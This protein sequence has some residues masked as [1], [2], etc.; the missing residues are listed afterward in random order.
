MSQ[1]VKNQSKFLKALKKDADN[2]DKSLAKLFKQRSFSFSGISKAINSDVKKANSE[3]SK[4]KKNL[5]SVG[6]IKIKTPKIDI[7]TAGRRKPDSSRTPKVDVGKGKEELD[8]LYGKNRKSKGVVHRLGK[9]N[10]EV[11]EPIGQVKNVWKEQL[12]SLHQYTDEAKKLYLAQAKF[13]LI[14]LSPDENTRAF[15]AVNKV[16]REMGTVTR[17]EGI[18]TLTD[19]HTALGSLPHAIESLETASKYRFSMKTLF[20]DK[21]GDSEIEGQ[22][23][24]AYKFL[25]V[26]GK[27]AKGSEEMNKAFN[28]MTQM[29]T[30]TGGRVMPSEMLL[31]GRRA[32]ASARNLSPE[33][34][35]NLSAPIQELGGSGLGVAL[36]T[37]YQALVG[38]T[39]KEYS[40]EAFNRLGL[41]D[42]S[43]IEYGKSGKIKNLLPGANK[44]GDLMM[45][46]PL[47]AA[48][49]LHQAMIAH[50]VKDDPKEISKQLTV[51]FG[52]RN[53][54]NLMDILINQR[55]QV[56]K[57]SGLAAHSQ[58]NDQ[59]FAGID[60]PLKDL[61]K[62]EIAL[63]DLKTEIGIPLIKTFSQLAESA[64]P[65]MHFFAEN[66]AITQ[67]GI[68][69]LFA[70]KA[71][72]LI[73]ETSSILSGTGSGLISFFSSSAN[74]ADAMA[75]SVSSAATKTGKLS[76]VLG[77]LSS[78]GTVG[79]AVVGAE[80]VS[81]YAQM[82]SE[83]AEKSRQVAE[84]SKTIGQ[85]YDALM[86][87]GLLY[88]APGDY[89][90][91]KGRFDS[92]ADKI[93]D[94][95]KRGG[96]L[97]KALHP[98][99]ANWWETF[100]NPTPYGMTPTQSQYGGAQFSPD[101]AAQMWREAG[102]TQQ[103][104][105]VNMLARTISKVQSGGDKDTRLN[106]TDIGLLMQ[107]L[108]KVTSKDKVATA[109]E[110]L[111]KE[112]YGD[113][114]S[115]PPVPASQQ[116]IPYFSLDKT[117][118]KPT[119][120][121]D[122][123]QQPLNTLGQD[124]FTLSGKASPLGDTFSGLN[125]NA[126]NSSGGILRLGDAASGVAFR[127][128]SLEIRPPT[129]GQI[130]IPNFGQK[131]PPLT[132]G[133]KTPSLF[134]ANPNF[135]RMFGG[136]KGRAKGGSV[137]KGSAYEVGE[138]GKE[139]FVP[140]ASGSIVGNNILRQKRESSSIVQHT[141]NN[142]YI[143]GRDSDDIADKVV[144]RMEVLS[145]RVN[146]LE[147]LNDPDVLARRVASSAERHSER[148]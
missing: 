31:M 57:E 120:N 11:L 96:D 103:L 25:E 83:A 145:H 22:I 42:Q 88:N 53:A 64:M 59:M 121:F 35:R 114:S 148:T 97:E 125:T 94:S 90:G 108:E 46:D 13:K 43:K 58:N 111:K 38:G 61:Q 146:K 84:N 91:Q 56:V 27:V 129:F 49:M 128:G 7:P 98:E 65:L 147:D 34:L 14:N 39:M 18:E 139:M 144:A 40:K 131:T 135:L 20:G 112:K 85:E 54:Q 50:G 113:K 101:V 28:A 136:A 107:T 6:N 33:G 47:S 44:L 21:F 62:F 109:L 16:V 26:T 52:N 74:K 95:M 99:K 23:Q 5:A 15:E 24:N 29:S 63:T 66:E 143:T 30:A 118:E 67:W 32:G 86:G 80:A 17:T 138:V 127:L 81:L 4:L 3:I 117:K 134:P 116:N 126:G 73:S 72:K 104:Q 141:T 130:N 55:A 102:I 8:K 115:L 12:D 1:P 140:D 70:G 124:F 75:T 93:F 89:K 119:E 100:T 9:F 45:T 71:L 19:L 133:Q 137:T 10:D 122:K 110:I 37:M 142:F 76:N 36:M 106:N 123:L 79:I 92:Q 41:I 132:F 105:D 2:L 87:L 82:W 77:K 78:V 69:L 48:D 68:K 60:K 51:L